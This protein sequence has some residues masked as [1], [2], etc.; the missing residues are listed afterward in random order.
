LGRWVNRQRSAFQKNKL[1]KEYVDKL[2]TV[3]LRWV[4]HERKGL[5]VAVSPTI[6]GIPDAVKSGTTNVETTKEVVEKE[7]EKG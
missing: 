2:T 3:G 6:N 1:K 5:P 7:N 4:I